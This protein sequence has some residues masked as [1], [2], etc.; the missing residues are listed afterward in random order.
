MDNN[1]L[2]EIIKLKNCGIPQPEDLEFFDMVAQA[3]S[4][5]GSNIHASN[6][7]HSYVEKSPSSMMAIDQGFSSD[8]DI[9]AFLGRRHII[10]TFTW[11]VGGDLVRNINPWTAFLLSNAV[12]KKI[13][14]YYLIKGDL[15]ITIFVNGTP[16]HSGMALASYSY[17]N[18]TNELVTIGGDTQLITR[19]QR[20][21]VYLNPST[22]K[23][24]CICAPFLWPHNYFNLVSTTHSPDD[25][26]RLNID[27]FAPLQQINGGTDSVTFTVFARMVNVKLT[28]PTT[29]PV[30][31]SSLTDLDFNE[32]FT[33]TAQSDEYPDEGI[34]SGPANAVATYAGLLS[35]APII[36][37]FALATEI[38]ATAVGRI[39]KLFGY[40]KPTNNSDISPMRNFPISSLS[41]VEGADSSQKLT[42]T[43]K[44]ELS[45]DP[46]LCE[47]PSEDLLSLKSMAQ[48]ETYVETFDWGVSDTSTIFAILV[49]PMWERR[50][51]SG[52]DRTIIPTSL[53]FATR[54]F[55]NWSGTLRYRFQIVGSQYHRGRLAFIYDPR[56]S[57]GT[58][59]YNTTFNVIVD[60]A[61]GR[62][63]TIEVPWQQDVPYCEVD[64]QERQFFS[65]SVNPNS[66]QADGF[67][68]GVLYVRVVNE[69]VVPDSTTGVKVLVSISAGD[70]Y[71]VANPAPVL[72]K[73]SYYSI[74]QS[75]RSAIDFDEYFCNISQ[76]SAVE[77][78]PVEENSP[79]A[80]IN[81][82]PIVTKSV[83][84]VDQKP[85]IFYGER[86]ASYRQLLKRYTYNI[87]LAYPSTVAR[88]S[89][90]EVTIRSIPVDPGFATNGPHTTA[91]LANYTYGG[92]SYFS[93]VKRSFA[94]WRG[95]IRWKI[96]PLTDNKVTRVVRWTGLGNNENAVNTTFFSYN[97]NLTTA[98][99]SNLAFA[100]A[101]AYS[102]GTSA[103][104]ALTLNNTQDGLEFEV[105]MAVPFKFCTTKLYPWATGTNQYDSFCPGGDT[106]RIIATSGTTNSTI[107]CDT[108]CAAGEDIQF[109]GWIGASVIY[110][111]AA[112]P[113]PQP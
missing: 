85:L 31:H 77:V 7:M 42:M 78:V 6:T 4:S 8:A 11:S 40:S 53:S 30:G 107:A 63:F 56:G 48:R 5:T 43:A 36:G 73:F 26:G 69:L 88:A 52:S 57:L 28:A 44:Q 98:S 61:E 68:N 99:I 37:P 54:P 80:S 66:L 24:G 16:F 45:I 60:L 41:L 46:R 81:I 82:T 50:L 29:R 34:I 103:G 87:L 110:Y 93:Y 108:Y 35:S 89:T 94:G 74:A 91:A 10:D 25:L 51:V 59:P 70:D 106:I 65:L 104:A 55:S 27:S 109:M 47:M 17:M 79:E 112:L 86:F 14:N 62:D 102:K 75:S 64:Y 105:P 32:F 83:D 67:S 3:D 113:S 18:E 100:Y 12:V 38:G 13:D 9:S 15:E 22:C 2:M 20:P 95:S 71:E 76:A 58:D 72:D 84:M 19:S 33:N 96:I 23:G 101:A 97:L 90:A 39:A 92:M 1:A 111:D 21:H 49:N